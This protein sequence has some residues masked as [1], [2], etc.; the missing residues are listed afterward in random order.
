MQLDGR[1]F[2]VAYSCPVVLQ[3]PR[4]TSSAALVSA[5]SGCHL[6]TAVSDDDRSLGQH[7]QPMP[8]N[9]CAC[10]FSASVAKVPAFSS[11]SFIVMGRV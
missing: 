4:V 8:T 9:I 11:Y 7:L 6:R 3:H 2:P 10:Y 1:F 5:V